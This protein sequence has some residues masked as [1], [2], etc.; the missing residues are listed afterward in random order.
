MLLDTMVQYII[1][2]GIYKL[3]GIAISADQSSTAAKHQ[4][5]KQKKGNLVDAIHH[6]ADREE[7]RALV[8]ARAVH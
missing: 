5:R 7:H 2:N 6:T 4:Y 8:V 1:K 3:K